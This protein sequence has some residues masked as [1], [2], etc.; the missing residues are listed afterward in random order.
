M[1]TTT[2]T[3]DTLTRQLEADGFQIGKPAHVRPECIAI[4]RETAA[5]ASCDHCGHHGLDF[6]PFR[7]I[8]GRQR[9]YRCIAWCSA[10]DTA[11]EF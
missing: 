8:D 11:I 5:E 10:C 9:G 6:L 4:D 3:R 7:P 2:D 1:T